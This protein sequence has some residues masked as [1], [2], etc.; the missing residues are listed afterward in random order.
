MF[1]SCGVMNISADACN[2]HSK[3]SMRYLQ[4]LVPLR[5]A[6]LRNTSTAPQWS[7]DGDPSGGGNPSGVEVSICILRA[8]YT[9]TEQQVDRVGRLC[10]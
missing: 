7:D 9:G 3:P 2:G 8:W 1:L 6:D 10:R 5:G 4:R